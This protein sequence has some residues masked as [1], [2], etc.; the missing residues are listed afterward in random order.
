MWMVSFYDILAVSWTME[1]C[2]G[3]W[4][5]SLPAKCIKTPLTDF[6]IYLYDFEGHNSIIDTNGVTD[7]Y[8]MQ[9]K[10]RVTER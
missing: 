1:T 3:Q 7:T 10:C 2:F 6:S 4:N 9:L 5:T 8:F